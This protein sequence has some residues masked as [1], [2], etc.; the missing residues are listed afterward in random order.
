MAKI[1]KG[2]IIISTIGSVVLT[3][4][5]A[6]RDWKKVNK[7]KGRGLTL[8]E[9]DAA[10]KAGR[11]NWAEKEGLTL[12]E[13]DAKYAESQKQMLERNRDLVDKYMRK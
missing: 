3:V 1:W 2:W 4:W 12:E 7:A 13:L 11:K 9:L 8:E 5:F 6:K 10:I